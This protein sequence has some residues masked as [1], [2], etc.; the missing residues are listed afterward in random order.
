[1]NDKIKGIVEKIENLNKNQHLQ[2]EYTAK[3]VNIGNELR[4]H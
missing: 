4:S 2:S 3:F 1:M